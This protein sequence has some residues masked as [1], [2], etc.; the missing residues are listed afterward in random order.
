MTGVIGPPA[1]DAA[2]AETKA[3]ARIDGDSEDAMLTRLVASATA[4]CEAFTG[5]WLMRREGR[6][7][8]AADGSWRRLRAAPV[9]AISG[10]AAIAD[11]G[12]TSPLAAD[13]YRID[14]DA[15]GDGWVLV[16]ATGVRRAETMF[17]AG[18]GAGWNDLPEPIRQ[19]IVRL[20]AHLHAA[21]EE[22]G[23]VA[24]SDGGH[25]GPGPRWRRHA[26]PANGQR[27]PPDGRAGRAAWAHD[28]GAT[29]PSAARQQVE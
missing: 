13:A 14:I 26:P 5:Q 6:E 17:E 3:L 18:L 29:R 12:S 2:V 9:A 20:A 4:V 27:G 23:E 16:R 7:A 28:A 8:V 11:D 10:V 24:R 1:L 15:N 22:A 19:G 25:P 21:R